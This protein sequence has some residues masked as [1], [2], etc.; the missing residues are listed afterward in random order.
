M[1]DPVAAHLADASAASR[2]AV[3]RRAAAADILQER[4]AVKTHLTKA[5]MGVLEATAGELAV[6]TVNRYLEIKM[7]HAL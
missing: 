4:D 5:G 1:N 6:A 7:R 2:D 3:Y